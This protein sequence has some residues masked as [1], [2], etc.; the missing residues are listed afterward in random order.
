V[1]KYGGIWA[2]Y[3]G[4]KPTIFRAMMLNGTKFATYDTI[5]H[6]IIDSGTIEDG[7]KC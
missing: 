4:V 5:K 2:F 6:K 7:I 3:T 1:Y